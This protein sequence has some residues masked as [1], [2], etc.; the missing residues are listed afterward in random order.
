[1]SLSDHGVARMPESSSADHLF[2]IGLRI[3]DRDV[4]VPVG[5]PTLQQ[6]DDRS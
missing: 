2:A 6:F 5:I 1:M 4:V 3:R